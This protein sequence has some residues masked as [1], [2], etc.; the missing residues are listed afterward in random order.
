[1]CVWHT[2]ALGAEPVITT[3]ETSSPAEFADL[4][5][6]CWGNDT[7]PMGKQRAADGHP[8]QYKLRFIELG[9]VDKYEAYLTVRA[10]CIYI[11]TAVSSKPP[12]RFLS[13]H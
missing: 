3:T 7:T 4:V 6:Y 10:V 12:P 9:T 2:V 5:E 13:D 1:V 11:S 8:D